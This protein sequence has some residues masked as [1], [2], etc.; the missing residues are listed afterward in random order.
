MAKMRSMMAQ[1]EYDQ[2]IWLE[3]TSNRIWFYFLAVPLYY[4]SVW[5]QRL[6]IHA[7]QH[8][9]S[10]VLP[11]VRGKLPRYAFVPRRGK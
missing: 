10:R 5:L 3:R 4:V 2:T 6:L 8:C 1:L 7:E 11:I 9:G